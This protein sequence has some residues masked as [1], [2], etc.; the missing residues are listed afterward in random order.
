MDL[1]SSRNKVMLDDLCNFRESKKKLK[2]TP[3]GYLCHG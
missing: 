2:K 1:F 3:R